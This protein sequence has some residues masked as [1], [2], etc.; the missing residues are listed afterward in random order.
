MQ[1]LNWKTATEMIC[2]CGVCMHVQTGSRNPW[3]LSEA[4]S[5][6]VL[7]RTGL[8]NY[9]PR[10]ESSLLLILVHLTS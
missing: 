2:V 5:G 4:H 1:H 6:G 3:H 10:A 7:S 9:G 8:A